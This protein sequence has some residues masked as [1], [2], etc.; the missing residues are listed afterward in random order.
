MKY[1]IF[2]LFLLFTI[3]FSGCNGRIEDGGAF[4]ISGLNGEE[5]SLPERP[6]RII[7]LAPN[8]LE[9]F[10]YLELEGLLVGRVDEAS[11]PKESD[12]IPS[13][14]HFQRPDIEKIIKQK[15]DLVI[16]TGLV[17]RKTTEKLQQLNIPVLEL[18]ITSIKD[19][20][21]SLEIIS[22]FSKTPNITK[23]KIDSLKY[24]F[25][26]TVYPK[27]S[28]KL[29]VLPIIWWDPLTIA[30]TETILDSVL[31]RLGFINIASRYISGY[32]KINLEVV[33]EENP[34]IILII[35]VQDYE[36]IIKFMKDDDIWKKINAVKN[37]KI[38]GDI[39]PDLL[40]RP[41]PRLVIGMEEII[42][43]ANMR[44]IFN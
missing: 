41:G 17:Q 35:G 1:K 24:K 40:L 19:L 31:E 27:S 14:G 30:G 18:Y 25:N 2:I 6:N 4:K 10:Y 13:V 3:L 39:D 7:V 23:S 44:T 34:D 20:I 8:L 9:I 5:I 12:N 38:I 16:T 32:K 15:P 11:F 37:D 33:L 22:Q 28:N 43:R 36:N 26:N 21:K 42:K 29:K